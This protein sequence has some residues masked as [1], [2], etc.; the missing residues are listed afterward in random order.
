MIDT[1]KNVIAKGT[2]EHAKDAAQDRLEGISERLKD[3]EVVQ[4]L[5]TKAKTEIKRA[6]KELKRAKK[7][8]GKK[9][10]SRR[11]PRPFVLLVALGF[12]GLA[13]YMM[14]RRRNQSLPDVGPD[15]FGEAVEEERRAGAFGQ[16]P[17]A[18]PG[19]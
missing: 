4:Q 9:S 12:V 11:A 2:V 7:A 19:A 8:R 10:K 1:A 17:A 14:Q 18:T 6:K 3:A 15:P 5:R 13:V 16:R